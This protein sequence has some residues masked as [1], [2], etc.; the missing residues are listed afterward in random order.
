MNRS[1]LARRVTLGLVASGTALAGLAV[2]APAFAAQPATATQHTGS[3]A[4]YVPV[5]QCSSLAG[6]VSFTPGLRKKAHTESGFLNG[7]LD[8]C[9][10]DGQQQPGQGSLTISLSGSAS[11]GAA[12]LTGTF[13]ANWPA[14][15]GLNPSNGSVTVTSAS[16]GSYT[17]TGTVTS[18]AFTGQI[19][20][21]AY[22]V[23]GTTGTGRKHDPITAQ[24]I[25][26]TAPIE[27]LENIG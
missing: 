19:F 22:V 13:T 17:I 23:T 2:S 1:L 5:E 15:A 20:Q 26:N 12:A 16:R 24:T 21:G 7:T 14:S 27:I 4:G 11:V 25:V 8:G 6:G 18:G 3:P 9:S 10:I